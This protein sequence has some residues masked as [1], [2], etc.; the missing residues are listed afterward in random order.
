MKNGSEDV[1]NNAAAY[2]TYVGRWS[3]LVARQF[4]HWLNIETESVWLDVG[5][6]T[7]ILTQVILDQASPKKIIG[8]DTSE[9]YLEYARHSVSDERVEFRVGDVD[10][11]KLEPPDFDVAVA[12]LVLNFLPSSQDGIQ[13][14]KDATKVDGTVAAYVWDYGERMQMMRYFWD[15]AITVDPSANAFDSGRRFTICDPRNLQTVFESA[16]LKQVEVMPIDIQTTF[17]NFDDFWRPF[18]SAQGSVSKYLRSLDEEKRTVIRDHLRQQLPI[19][20]DGMIHL[21]ARAWAAKGKR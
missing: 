18:L 14:M 6:G 20:S 15:S 3:K 19:E 21:T 10:S 7:G 17:A 4:I 9:Y 16:G 5:A 13:S 1:F 8:V 11:I 12:G 2:E